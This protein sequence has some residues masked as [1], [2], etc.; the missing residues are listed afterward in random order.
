MAF[1]FHVLLQCWICRE[2]CCGPK[3]AEGSPEARAFQNMVRK[4]LTYVQTPEKP[5]LD[6]GWEILFRMRKVIDDQGKSVRIPRGVQIEKFEAMSIPCIYVHVLGT[7]DTTPVCIYLHG[8]QYML[9]SAE[10]SVGSVAKWMVN[11]PADCL[12]V[13][14]RLA[15]EYSLSVGLQDCVRAYRWLIETKKISPHRIVFYGESA[16]GALALRML[17][18]LRDQQ[19]PLPACALVHSGYLDLTSSMPSF[20]LNADADVMLP[21]S[22]FKNPLKPWSSE[23][24]KI[25]CTFW[26]RN[27]TDF[28]CDLTCFRCNHNSVVVVSLFADTIPHVIVVLQK[29]S[30]ILAPDLTGLP[31]V[32]ITCSTTER[33]HDE[34]VEMANRLRAAGVTVELEEG[35]NLPHA[36]GV[37][38]GMFPEADA[39]LDRCAA[40][41]H[42]HVAEGAVRLGLKAPSAEAAAAVVAAQTG[43]PTKKFRTLEDEPQ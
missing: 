28:Q 30:P 22:F 25:W 24:P 14:Y 29:Y 4:M 21:D 20:K 15:P 35:K 34:N 43:G 31:P 3:H 1:L 12:I 9:G 7:D 26:N 36:Y 16:G 32:Y 27:T 33:F 42:R 13:D 6:E 23:D 18:S 41:L 10:A 19:L 5:T 40:F 8:G 2:K 39:T 17:M 37:M 38:I 11:I